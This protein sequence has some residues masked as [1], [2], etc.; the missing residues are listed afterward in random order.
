MAYVSSGSVVNVF[1]PS[2]G[3]SNTDYIETDVCTK[4]SGN[5]ET[6][7]IFA[8]VATKNGKPWDGISTTNI[9]S[10]YLYTT[11]SDYT[12]KITRK[13]S[14]TPSEEVRYVNGYSNGMLVNDQTGENVTINGIPVFKSVKDADKYIKTGDFSNAQN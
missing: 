7:G 3:D 1:H 14:W 11:S 9:R 4:E 8:I 12:E 10:V 6:S 5:E 2:W 13:K